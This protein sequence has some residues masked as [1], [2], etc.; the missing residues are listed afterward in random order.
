[1]LT[2]LKKR[3]AQ[4]ALLLCIGLVAGGAT[5]GWGT[6]QYTDGDEATEGEGGCAVCV[7]D[8]SRV[9]AACGKFCSGT[10]SNSSCSAATCVGKHGGTYTN[11]G[12]C[13]MN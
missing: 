11:K 3:V 4:T 1:M 8:C 13:T 2:G 12:T 9:E 10:I 6:E 7:N 5:P